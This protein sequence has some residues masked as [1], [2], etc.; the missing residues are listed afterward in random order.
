MR[1]DKSPACKKDQE[2]VGCKKANRNFMK[3]STAYETLSD[4]EKR[5]FYD[6]T[7]FADKEAQQEVNSLVNCELRATYTHPPVLPE[8]QHFRKNEQQGQQHRR[9][10]GGNTDGPFGR[11]GAQQAPKGPLPIV[12][13]QSFSKY[14]SDAVKLKRP[15]VRLPVT[16]AP[17][18]YTVIYPASLISCH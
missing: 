10:G 12:T 16:I 8:L 5:R 15:V 4:P 6:Q 13:S 18:F 9:H 14:L 2:S 1:Q 17:R 3:L 7:G 11:G